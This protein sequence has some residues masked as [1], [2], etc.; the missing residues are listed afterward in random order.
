M[1]FNTIK[2][3][4]INL[5]TS[6]YSSETDIKELN[7]NMKDP[8]VKL[9]MKAHNIKDPNINQ[10]PDQTQNNSVQSKSPNNDLER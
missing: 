3:G 7:Y 10:A 5:F 4:I 2:K 9:F 1:C 8:T 6:K